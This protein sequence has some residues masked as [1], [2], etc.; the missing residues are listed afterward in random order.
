V[1]I[2]DDRD[3]ENFNRLYK[4]KRNAEYSSDIAR[5]AYVAGLEGMGTTYKLQK[6]ILLIR[7]WFTAEILRE[8][9]LK[10]K[11]YHGITH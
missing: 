1:S 5:E 10:L 9:N 11:F 2:I 7:T 4:E 6:I 8:N 3:V